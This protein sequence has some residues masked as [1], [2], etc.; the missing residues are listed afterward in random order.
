MSNSQCVDHCGCQLDPGGVLMFSCTFAMIPF[1]VCSGINIVYG[2]VN[3]NL[4]I[5]NAVWV[6][7]DGSVGKSAGCSSR[8]AELVSSHPHGVSQP[9]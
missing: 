8:G 1:F 4:D 9:A 6:W 7:G 3:K 5:K 2:G